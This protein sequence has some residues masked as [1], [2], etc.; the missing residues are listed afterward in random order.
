M[1]DR[2][3]FAIPQARDQETRYTLNGALLVLK[4]TCVQMVATDGH[5]PPL[6]TV[7]GV[8]I[9]VPVMVSVCSVCNRTRGGFPESVA[10]VAYLK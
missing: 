6:A 5:R 3:A 9:E 1:I 7:I 10:S 8:L 2:T 4:P